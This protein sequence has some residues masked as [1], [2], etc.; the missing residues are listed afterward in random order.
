MAEQD[1]SPKNALLPSTRT[2]V[3]EESCIEDECR[4]FLKEKPANGATG[5]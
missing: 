2:A 5:S 1:H 4:V 3:E